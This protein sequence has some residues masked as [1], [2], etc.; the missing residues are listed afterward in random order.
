M[1]VLC[2]LMP[3]ALN[4]LGTG[5]LAGMSL[6]VGVLSFVIYKISAGRNWA[7]ILYLT[8]FLVGTGAGLVII[9]LV[10]TAVAHFIWLGEL[11]LQ[12]AAMVLVFS[13]PAN[14]WFKQR[15]DRQVDTDPESS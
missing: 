8:F 11:L 5:Y 10:K 4:A 12:V 9:G 6:G 2:F 15:A 1:I 7:R 14:Q 3:R 13:G